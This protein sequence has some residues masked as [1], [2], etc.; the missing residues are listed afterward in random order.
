MYTTLF[1]R[2]SD[3]SLIY[4]IFQGSVR[5]VGLIVA[6]EAALGGEEGLET[7][8][9]AVADSETVEDSETGV[10]EA[11]SAAE[12]VSN[13]NTTFLKQDSLCGH[14]IGTTQG[15]LNQKLQ[16]IINE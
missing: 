12:V 6:V 14:S 9:A 7:V 3:T 2:E 16:Y 1:L 5:G 11:D 10:E 13:I 4:F 15:F 8:E